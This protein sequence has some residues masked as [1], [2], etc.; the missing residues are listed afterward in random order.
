M[1]RPVSKTRNII[2]RCEDALPDDTV[3]PGTFARGK[4]ALGASEQSYKWLHK[5]IPER[6]LHSLGLDTVPAVGAGVRPEEHGATR[7]AV[8]RNDGNLYF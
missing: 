3:L 8:A 7:P 6:L 2:R 5:E 4:C 1:N